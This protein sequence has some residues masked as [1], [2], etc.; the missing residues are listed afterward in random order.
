MYQSNM[1]KALKE[2]QRAGSK[3]GQAIGV[4]RRIKQISNDTYKGIYKVTNWNITLQKI[5]GSAPFTVDEHNC[6]AI[7]AELQEERRQ[8][9][10]SVYKSLIG[11]SKPIKYVLAWKNK[12]NGDGDWVVGIHKHDSI[13]SAEKR[14]QIWARIWPDLDY[15]IVPLGVPDYEGFYFNKW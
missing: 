15:K 9:E 13:E 5:D 4:I 10:S 1:M 12:L 7:E 6:V 2:S 3:I 11:E 14:L 8:L